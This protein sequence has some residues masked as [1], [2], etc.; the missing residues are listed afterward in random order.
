MVQMIPKKQSQSSLP[1][2]FSIVNC[3]F[4]VMVLIAAGILHCGIAAAAKTSSRYSYTA[5]NE[6]VTLNPSPNLLVINDSNSTKKDLH[7]K[8]LA[9]IGVVLDTLSQKNGLKRSGLKLYRRTQLKSSSQEKGFK[10]LVKDQLNDENIITQPVFEQ[11]EALLIPGNEIIVTFKMEKKIAE[12][13]QLL[14]PLM[15]ELEITEIKAAGGNSLL[16]TINHPDDGRCYQ[17]CRE[18][19][20][21]PGLKSAE[22][23]HLIITLSDQTNSQ[24]DLNIHIDNPE[25]LSPLSPKTDLKSLPT[26]EQPLESSLNN[27]ADNDWQLLAELDAEKETYPPP[28]WSLTCGKGKTT[29]AWGRT[30]QRSFAGEHSLYCAGYGPGAVAAPGPAPVNMAGYLFSPALDLSS[31]NEVYVEVWFYAKNEILLDD[32][33]QPQAR[34]LPVIGVT[35]GNKSCEKY[36]TVIHSQ[37]DCTRDPTTKKGWRKCLF[38]IPPAFH[39]KSVKICFLYLSD[40]QNPK[41]GC[42]LDNI[43][44]VGS[45]ITKKDAKIGNDPYCGA[46]YEL[47]NNGQIAGLGGSDNDMNVKSAWTLTTIDKDLVVA[48]IDDGVELEHPDLNLVRGYHPNGADGGGPPS[49]DANHGT[50]VAGNIGAIGNNNTGVMGIAP[51]VKIMPI[52]GGNSVIERAA[53]IRL[54]VSKGAKIINNSWGWVGAPSPQIEEAIADALHAGVIVI[55][56]AGNGPDRPPFTYDVAFPGKLTE[57]YDLICVGAT[58]LTDEHKSAASSDGEFSWGSSYI[59]P[60]PDI[61]A[62]GPWSYTTDR[63]GKLGYND[64][65]SGINA[66]YC[67]SFGGTSSSCPKVTG[68]VA[69]MLSANPQLTPAEVKNILMESADDIDEPGIDDKTGAGRVNAFKAVQMAQLKL[70]PES[71]PERHHSDNNNSHSVDAFSSPGQNQPKNLPE[72]SPRQNNWQNVVE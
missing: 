46:Q 41:E 66:D 6:Q 29:A 8:S 16:L 9:R 36:L 23:N 64:G 63:I 59:G 50:S 7:T 68:V 11:G 51:N 1:A 21:L 61:C 67:T 57:N 15:K 42:Y 24:P 19:I 18:L 20:K 45:K 31:F 12:Q 13:K 65:S 17:V 4:L 25:L 34:D 69:L 44:I 28:G 22:P 47:I 62:P 54:A 3:R 56:A 53:A 2:R 32:K 39:K 58:S 37:G 5:G 49:E 48:V 35:D 71:Q 33:N 72:K 10:S 70:T 52:N 43:R 38:R 30:D 26:G 40:G 60:G 55:F 27:S 14:A